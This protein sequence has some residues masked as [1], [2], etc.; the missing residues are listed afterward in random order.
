MI[1]LYEFMKFSNIYAVLWKELS[2]NKAVIVETLDLILRD[3]LQY[4]CFVWTYKILQ[5][6]NMQKILCFFAL[7]IFQ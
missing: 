7:V 5:I 6:H 4:K 1:S 3:L 2:G